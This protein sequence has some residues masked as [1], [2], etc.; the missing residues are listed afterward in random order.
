MKMKKSKIKMLQQQVAPKSKHTHKRQ[1]K[2]VR[3]VKIPKRESSS[4]AICE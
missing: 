4:L 1:E 3:K 2:V